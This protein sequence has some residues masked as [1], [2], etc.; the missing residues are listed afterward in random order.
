[1]LKLYNT[2]TKQKEEFEPMDKENNL[3]KIY[4]CGLTV[5]NYAHIGNIN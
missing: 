1:M 5:Y 2:L 3:V 4:S